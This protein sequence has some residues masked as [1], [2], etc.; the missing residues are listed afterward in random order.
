M[1]VPES[2]FDLYEL[3]LG[4]VAGASLPGG[5]NLTERMTFTIEHEVMIGVETLPDVLTLTDQVLPE[6]IPGDAP[7]VLIAK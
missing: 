1:D 3:S 4:D 7:V 5:M 6:T 2:A